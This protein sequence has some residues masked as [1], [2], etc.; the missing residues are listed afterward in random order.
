MAQQLV[1][2]LNEKMGERYL[3]LN[4]VTAWTLDESIEELIVAVGDCEYL[5]YRGLDKGFDALVARLRSLSE[6]LWE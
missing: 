2:V 4:Q 5:Y 6:K 1:G 3:D